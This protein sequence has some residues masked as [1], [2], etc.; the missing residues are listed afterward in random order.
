MKRTITPTAT[1][2]WQSLP[3]SLPVSFTVCVSRDDGSHR[4]DNC[5]SMCDYAL[6]VHI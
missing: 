2:R 3:A 5:A 4:I 6:A 1:G